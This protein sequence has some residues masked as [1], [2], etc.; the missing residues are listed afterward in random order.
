MGTKAHYLFTISLCRK[1]HDALHR[2]TKAFESENG[3]QLLMLLRTLDRALALGVIATD[4][5]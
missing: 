2:D 3:S 1:C 5:K 4:K